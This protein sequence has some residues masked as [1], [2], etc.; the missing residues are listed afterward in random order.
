[1]YR[2]NMVKFFK[3]KECKAVKEKYTDTSTR[4]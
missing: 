4:R 2:Q 1:M 3:I